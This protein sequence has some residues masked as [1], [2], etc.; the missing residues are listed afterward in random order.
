MLATVLP[1]AYSTASGGGPN[2]RAIT[3]ACKLITAQCLITGIC[4]P[5]SAQANNLFVQVNALERQTS[6]DRIEAALN[7]L[8]AHRKP[9][10]EAA[11][12][13][14]SEPADVESSDA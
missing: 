4:Q 5:N 7:A 8:I 12:V 13:V 2:L 11:Q 1:Y 3:A 9:A 10:V 14:E 6:T